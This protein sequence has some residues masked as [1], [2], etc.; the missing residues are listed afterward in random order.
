MKNVA[1]IIMVFLSLT[2]HSQENMAVSDFIPNIFY[3]KQSLIDHY[4]EMLNYLTFIQDLERKSDKNLKIVSRDSNQIVY[5]EIDSRFSD[6]ITNILTFN[7]KKKLL[8]WSC[9]YK[10]CYNR[11]GSDVPE[12]YISNVDYKYTQTG[13]LEQISGHCASKNYSMQNN[14]FYN[15]ENRLDSI[16]FQEGYSNLLAYRKIIFIDTSIISGEP[17]SSMAL[18]LNTKFDYTKWLKLELNDTTYLNQIQSDEVVPSRVSR[19]RKI[20]FGS[21]SGINY[22]Y[23][24]DSLGNITSLRVLDAN[25]AYSS[26]MPSNVL[27]ICEENCA[28]PSLFE[29]YYKEHKMN[30]IDMTSFNIPSEEGK[31][32]CRCLMKIS[33]R[34]EK[35]KEIKFYSFSENYGWNLVK[36]WTKRKGFHNPPEN[37]VNSK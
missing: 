27:D 15:K 20:E 17:K 22:V 34:K 24:F 25:A 36:K 23:E 29:F 4:D 10:D 28:W 1:V 13:Q 6:T 26:L 30:G 3:T 12:P 11:L 35:I 32:M 14:Y 5:Q 8:K 7:P 9:D 19:N 16:I 33:Y 2:L 37:E 31:S 18:I 21:G